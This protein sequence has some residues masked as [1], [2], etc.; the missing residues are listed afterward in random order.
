MVALLPIL[1]KVGKY[2]LYLVPVI[3]IVLLGLH[4]YDLGTRHGE[5]KIQAEWNT[6][7]LKEETAIVDLQNQIQTKEETHQKEVAAISQ[8]LETANN[9][10]QKAIAVIQS[11]YD[12]RLRQSEDRAKVYQRQAAL[13]PTQCRSLASYTARLDG[14][15][16]QGRQLVQELRTTLGFR[17][18]QLRQLGKQLQSDRELIGN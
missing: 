10:H 11:D 17:D 16:E 13:G 1:L 18:N 12:E 4:I 2:L 9:D 15:I 8:S 7:K 5:A 6:D 14:S 3:L